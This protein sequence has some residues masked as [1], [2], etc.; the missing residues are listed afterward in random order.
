MAKAAFSRAGSRIAPVFDV[1]RPLRL[2]EAE[3]DRIVGESDAEFADDVPE[4]RAAQLLALGVS[5]VV[6]GAMSRPMHAALVARGLRVIPFVTGD[7][8]DVV[9]AWS[10][11]AVTRP[12][13][14][15]P[16]CRGGA[17]RRRRGASGA[18][19][20]GRAGSGSAQGGRM[21][22]GRSGGAGRGMGQGGGRGLGRGGGQGQGQGGGRG[23]GRGLGR[24]GGQLAAGA[25]GT[26]VCP[27]CG[28]REPHQRGVPCVQTQC[29][30]CG[31]AM[32]RGAS[33]GQ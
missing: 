26:C 8:R 32:T 17:L 10:S 22:I 33:D 21:A 20:E 30:K 2:V 15:M 1:A 18:G 7:L 5:A 6:C 24:M 11:G 31:T 13:F 4:R 3:G 29:P 23:G 28:H 25:F 16:G 12:A 27:A 9:Q 14:A 19:W